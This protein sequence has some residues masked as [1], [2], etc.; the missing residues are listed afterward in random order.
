MTSSIPKTVGNPP[1]VIESSNVWT[2]RPSTLR[3][4]RAV[5][6]MD[7]DN[8]RFLG[9]T[10]CSESQ[11]ST[12]ARKRTRPASMLTTLATNR[13]LPGRAHGL[14][15]LHILLPP[16]HRLIE[17]GRQH[18][19]FPAGGEMIRSVD[20][21]LVPAFF[22]PRMSDPYIDPL[23]AVKLRDA[24]RNFKPGGSRSACYL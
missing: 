14:P 24:L 22:G 7:G 3:L 19:R 5:Q 4:W 17:G 13:L 21:R 18:D 9:T 2:G 8:Y 1:S 16:D 12:Q 20:R 10:I 15:Q 6:S 23:T 11:R